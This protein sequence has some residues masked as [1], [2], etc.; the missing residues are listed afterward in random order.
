MLNKLK[1]FI[2][3]NRVLRTKSAITYLFLKYFRGKSTSTYKFELR[4]GLNLLV[5]PL[6]GDLCTF[7]EI[8]IQEVYSPAIGNNGFKKISILD[9]GANVGYF[10][11]YASKKFNE[12]KIF[13]FEPYYKSL[14]R[15]N[16]H[17]GMNNIKNVNTYPLAVSDRCG[18]TILYSIDWSGCNTIIANKF[19]KGYYTSNKVECINL[20][21]LFQITGINRFDL[22]KID[23][24]GSE[25][26]I[27][28]NSSDDA[29]KKIKNFIIE[30]H[31]DKK[32]KP[33]D[34]IDRFV[35]LQYRVLF[36]D[37]LLKASAI[38]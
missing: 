14:S 17:L 15:L 35:R 12:A 19:D 33:Q 1:S 27:L 38:N 21:R 10:S 18:E 28:L 32:Y 3:L 8:F 16:K 26:Q 2:N 37:A 29:I 22:A 11:V 9:I 34:L 20:Q 13:S 6:Q 23:C 36:N 24:E 4:N 7:Y 31:D 25:Y 30:V 5:T